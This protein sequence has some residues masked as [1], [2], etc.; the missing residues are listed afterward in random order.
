MNKTV[1]NEEIQALEVVLLLIFTFYLKCNEAL[2]FL[3]TGRMKK[4]PMA[5]LLKELEILMKFLPR[6]EILRITSI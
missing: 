5:L 6:V 1:F 4:N 2:I 3:D